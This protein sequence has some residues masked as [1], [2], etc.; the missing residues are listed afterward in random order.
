MKLF[1]VSEVREIWPDPKP[2]ERALKTLAKTYGCCRVLGRAF[3]FTQDDV[4]TLLDLHNKP[5]T[6]GELAKVLNCKVVDLR[7]L[8]YRNPYHDYMFDRPWL[9]V[10]NIRRLFVLEGER[11]MGA[12]EEFPSVVYFLADKEHVKIG[13]AKNL[14]ER[15][16]K[17]Q[18]AS[19]QNLHL[20]GFVAGG[21]D[22][23]A[24]LHERFKSHRLRGEWFVLHRDIRSFIGAYCKQ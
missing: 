15:I 11:L 6:L 18:I 3:G 14:R 4:D 24:K 7:K 13:H 22:E 10:D 23:E 1:S 8:R 21:A 16:S 19:A 5:K 2:T 12:A 9:Y 17:L 20:L